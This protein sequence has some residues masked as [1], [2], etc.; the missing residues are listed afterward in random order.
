MSNR[1]VW[2]PSLLGELEGEMPG[3]MGWRLNEY[4]VN[5]GK[6]MRVDSYVGTQDFLCA[7]IL[8]QEAATQMPIQVT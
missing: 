7:H 2:V 8:P 1:T 4:V 6:L 5:T 3:Y